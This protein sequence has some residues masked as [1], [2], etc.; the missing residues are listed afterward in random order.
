MLSYAMIAFQ[1]TY[2]PKLYELGLNT[3]MQYNTVLYAIAN[4]P[5]QKNLKINKAKLSKLFRSVEPIVTK[6]LHCTEVF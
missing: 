6:L 2:R 3:A 4:D 1:C 5:F